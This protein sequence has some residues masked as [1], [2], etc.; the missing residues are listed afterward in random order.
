MI[1]IIIHYQTSWFSLLQVLVQK[2]RMNRPWWRWVWADEDDDD[3]GYTG[4][5]SAHVIIHYCDTI[6]SEE[7]RH[8][9]IVQLFV[10]TVDLIRMCL[11]CWN[12]SSPSW[13][14]PLGLQLMLCLVWCFTDSFRLRRFVW[15]DWFRRVVQL[16][17]RGPVQTGRLTG[18][19]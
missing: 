13:T 10:C 11:M 7:S 19:V 15:V 14:E 17:W 5:T 6:T 9:R 4:N 8:V 1:T 18:T 16:D 12:I 3:A 2:G